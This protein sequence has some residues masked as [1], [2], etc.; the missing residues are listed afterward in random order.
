N[1]WASAMRRCRRCSKAWTPATSSCSPT[2]SRIPSS[3]TCA[4]ILATSASS[5]PRARK[6]PRRSKRRGRPDFSE[7]QKQKTRPKPG[8]SIGCAR[9]VAAPVAPR[10]RGGL[11]RLD[12]VGLQALLALHNLERHALAFLQRLE[13]GALDGTEVHEEVRAGF[14]RDEAKAL[15][16]VEPLDGAGLTIGHGYYSLKNRLDDA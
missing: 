9:H 3:T 13:A 2:S 10:I 15:G 5:P 4:R 11:D 12:F 14:R 16:I 7:R 8:F 6:R 1:T